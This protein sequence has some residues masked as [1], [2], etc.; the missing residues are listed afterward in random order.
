MCPS[1]KGGVKSLGVG[2]KGEGMKGKKEK[3][4]GK[5]GNRREKWVRVR[6]LHST[7]FTYSYLLI[8]VSLITDNNF[9]DNSGCGV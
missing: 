9:T 5:E 2:G 8:S 3:E 6:F 4:E 7:C 1:R